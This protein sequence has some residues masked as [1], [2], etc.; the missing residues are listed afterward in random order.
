M[1]SN[2][3]AA[4]W[5]SLGQEATSHKN[6]TLTLTH[7]A[8]LFLRRLYVNDTNHLYIRLGYKRL[9][10]GT[11]GRRAA[12]PLFFLYSSSCKAIFCRIRPFIG[13]TT[14]G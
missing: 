13:R 1:V 9:L 11:S 7:D 5:C 4:Q 10:S 2:F 6:K 12:E 3:D 8:A 14:T